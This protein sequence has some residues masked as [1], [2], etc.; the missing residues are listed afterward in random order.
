MTL[1]AHQSHEFLRRRLVAVL[2]A[3]LRHGATNPWPFRL[4]GSLAIERQST[5]A[6]TPGRAFDRWMDA[7]AARNG[8]ADSDV[9]FARVGLR[10]FCWVHDALLE[11]GPM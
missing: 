6:L 11:N 1:A 4:S 7:F 8:V 10:L 3:L 9:A 5:G 2:V